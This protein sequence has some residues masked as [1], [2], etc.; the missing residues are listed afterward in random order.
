[1]LVAGSVQLALLGAGQAGHRA[2]FD[3]GAEEAKVGRCL[4]CQDAAG[5]VAKIGA[6]KVE[7]YAPNQ[8]GAVVL[9]ETAVGAGGAA[10]A[11]AT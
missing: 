7:P 3:A 11:D 9:A 5:G 4:P 1:V 8:V 10:S 6:V 2:G